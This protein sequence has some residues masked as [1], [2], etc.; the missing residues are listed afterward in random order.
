M[1]WSEAASRAAALARRSRKDDPFDV[2]HPTHKAAM[3]RAL[4]SRMVEM[5]PGGYA[6][7]GHAAR[8]LRD[9]RRQLSGDRR[10]ARDRALLTRVVAGRMMQA[11]FKRGR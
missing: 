5:Y 6:D 1:A 10:P 4:K 2:G 8:L 9:A 11:S 3:L 7:R